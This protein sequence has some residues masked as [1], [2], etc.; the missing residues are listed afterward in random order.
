M[1]KLKFTHFSSLN[2]DI[3]QL[4]RF[5]ARIWQVIVPTRFP[6]SKNTETVENAENWG[7]LDNFEVVVIV[8]FWFTRETQVYVLTFTC[9]I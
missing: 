7:D 8:I 9:S 6:L 1:I 2:F 5:H 4:P 3:S